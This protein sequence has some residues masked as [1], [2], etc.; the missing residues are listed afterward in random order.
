MVRRTLKKV[1]GPVYGLD[2]TDEELLEKVKVRIPL[3]RIGK[4]KETADAVAFFLSDFSSFV[5]GQVLVV[6]GGTGT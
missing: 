3:G 4:P 6:G 5:T 1:M 2:K